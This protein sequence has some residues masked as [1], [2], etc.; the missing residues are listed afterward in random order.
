MLSDVF[1]LYLTKL[2]TI[3]LY[4]LG[5]TL[6]LALVG[7]VLWLLY[8]RRAARACLGAALAILWV[9]STPVVANW[10]I[11]SLERQYPAKTMADTPAA[12]VAIV[13]GGIIGQPLPPRVAPDL[14]DASDRVLHAAQLYRAGKVKRVLVSAGNIPWIPSVKPEAQLIRDL[15]IEWG[16]DAGAIQIGTESR[17]TFE[18]AMEIQRML[19]AKGF[20]SALLVT[21]AVHMPRAM[22]AF[23]RAGVPVIA[24]TTDV[25][26]VDSEQSDPL[27]WLPNAGALGATTIAMREWLGFVAYRLRGQL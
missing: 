12:D 5:L 17:T 19:K 10:A 13:L 27:L 9:A 7:L 6:S 18:N 2:V 23:R 1:L 20:T 8:Y 24:S 14:S 11:G 15:L 26:I 21:S 4:P 16:V 3:F 22:A 25:Q